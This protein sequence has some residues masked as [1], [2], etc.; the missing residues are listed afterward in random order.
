MVTGICLR[1]AELSKN[2]D[3][4]DTDRWEVTGGCYENGA[5]TKSVLAVPDLRYG[6]TQVQ[7]RL[8]LDDSPEYYLD[9]HD[10]EEVAIK[11]PSGWS[12]LFNFL[13][14]F[15]AILLFGTLIL[16]GAVTFVEQKQRPRAGL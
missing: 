9:S 2:H 11:K 12:K 14:Y 3:I 7:I 6:F 10:H 8:M 15:T 13:L 16:F 1:V 5:Y 4:E